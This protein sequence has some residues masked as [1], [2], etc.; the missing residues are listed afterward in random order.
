MMNVET[1]AAKLRLGIRGLRA[2]CAAVEREIAASTTPGAVLGVLHQDRDWY[3][4]A[5]YAN[6]KPMQG[7][8]VSTREETLYDCASLTK[9]VVTLPLILQLIDDGVLILTTK[10]SDILPSFGLAGKEGITVGQLLTH[11]SGLQADMNLHAQ[12]WSREQMWDAVLASPLAAKQNTEVIYSDLGYLTLGRIIEKVLGMPL[13][14][15]A[16]QRVFDPLNMRHAT[17]TPDPEQTERYAAT[18]YDETVQGHLC[19][20]VHDEKARALGGICGHAGLF[21]TAGDLLLYARM[22][23]GQGTIPAA[24]HTEVTGHVSRILSQAA[25]GTAVR[26]HTGHIQGSNRGLGWVLK[27]DKMDASGDWMSP[28]CYGHTGFTGTSLWIDPEFDLAVVL[29]TNRVYGGRS[30]SVAQLR[31]QVHNA[32]TGAVAK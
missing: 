15:A 22:W 8:S 28:G 7:Q 2:A 29:L 31:A 12:G 20:I 9:V 19:G 26:T 25:A 3:Y 16:K 13:D 18:E 21:A 6:P 1:G 27:G 11:T 5:G 24:P 10:V 14:Q 17:L 32:L 30:T 4:A 23:L